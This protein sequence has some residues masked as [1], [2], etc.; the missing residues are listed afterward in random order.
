M[1]KEKSLPYKVL[2]SHTT[3]LFNL[4]KELGFE[5]EKSEGYG[6]KEIRKFTKGNKY[7]HSTH[8]FVILFSIDPKT[9]KKIITSK[10]LTLQDEIL[11]FFANR[12]PII[13]NKEKV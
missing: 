13:I 5:E 10:S 8:Y 12:N 4:I 7:I 11:K 3:P 6:L 2:I 1:E 9:Q